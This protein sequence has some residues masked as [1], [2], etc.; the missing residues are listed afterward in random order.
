VDRRP[1]LS[2]HEWVVLAL[3]AEMPRHGYD[4]AAEA[5]PDAPLG[6]VWTVPRPAV[7][8][9][10]A[11]LEALGH[12]GPRRTEAG[13]GAPPRTIY[14]ATRRGRTA[15]RRWLHDP[16]DHL[17]DV[18]SELLAK[19]LLGERLGVARDDLVRAQRA[20]FAPLVARL[21]GQPPSPDPVE[22]WRRH[23]AR[24]VDA[25]LDELGG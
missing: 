15:V 20:A 1:D 17:R 7:Y 3:V 16:V 5:A 21:V 6:E 8:R 4:V 11:R 24:A 19:L 23:A 10:L 14:A 9:A 2:L 12:V 13:D 25:F 18:R 22:A